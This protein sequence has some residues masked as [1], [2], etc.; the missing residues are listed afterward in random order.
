MW[1]TCETCMRKYRKELR[2]KYKESIKALNDEFESMVC[3][4]CG[5]EHKTIYLDYVSMWDGYFC[6][7]C[8][9]IEEGMIK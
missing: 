7:K 4:G 1:F 2:A 9:E 8:I 3:D 5:I 6:L